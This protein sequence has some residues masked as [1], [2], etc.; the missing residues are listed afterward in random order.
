MAAD[1]F[2]HGYAT[3][4][5]YR[6]LHDFALDPTSPEYKAPLGRF[7]HARRVADPSDRTIVAMNVDTPYS[8][9]WLDLRGGPTVLTVPP[10]PEDRYVSAMI[11]DLYT[12]IVGYVSP[13]TNH[14]RGGRVLIVGPS[15]DGARPDGIDDVLACPTDLA[16]VFLR[17]QLFDADDLPNVVAVQDG[18]AVEPTR[19]HLEPAPLSPV[20]P[21]DVR[22]GLDPRFFDVMCWMLDLMPT[23]PEDEARRQQFA[24]IGIAPG[25]TPSTAPEPGRD[26]LLAGMQIGLQRMAARARTIRSSGEI[27][28]SREYFAGDDLSRACG[29]MLGILGNAAEEY[30]G[31]GYQ[32]D[33]DGQPFDG[34]ND[35]TITFAADA[36]PPVDA[37]WSITAYDEQRFLFAN[38]IDRYTIGT[39]DLPSLAR[40]DD[41]SITVLVSSRSPGP[42]LESNWLPVPPTPFT[43]A[44]R[45][46]LPGPDI[47]TGRW[48]APPV[49]R[50][51]F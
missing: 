30:L 22:V 12:Y 39:R 14:H 38:P 31:V 42:A 33:A 41:G 32:A 13:R 17:T 37:F 6:I 2:V 26:V 46:Y 29:A 16:L 40:A 28:G 49:V 5:L 50:A 23:L 48:T 7:H 10:T 35:Y 51:S 25:A 47:R 44:F 24:S 11:V 1:A 18:F 34:C 45:T 3:V 15:W 4:D 19:P 21:I 43:L 36:L 8:Y 20:T 27:F 9:A